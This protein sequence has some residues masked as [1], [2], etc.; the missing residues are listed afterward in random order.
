MEDV[1]THA[2]EEGEDGGGVEGGGIAAYHEGAFPG[3]GGV[4]VGLGYG[5]VD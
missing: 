4:H 5:G 2:F 1:G 3:G